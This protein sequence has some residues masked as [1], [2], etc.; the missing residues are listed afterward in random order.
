MAQKS[1]RTLRVSLATGL[2]LSG[3]AASSLQAQPTP[4]ET[5]T[6]PATKASVSTYVRQGDNAF[7]EGDYKTALAAY[8]EALQLFQGSDYIYYN[9]G[10]AHR[11]LEDYSAAVTD[12][13]QAL[14]LNPRHSFAYLYRGM[15]HHALEAFD[16]AITDYTTLIELDPQNPVAHIS[17]AET[18]LSLDQTAAAIADLEAA[19]ALYKKQK[20]DRLAEKTMSR[21]RSLR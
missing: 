2:L 15:S 6:P 17:R 16:A 10:N 21:V 1:F 14:Q 19:A 13:T 20:N 7:A 12:Y 3:L 8:S 9:R 5:D 11:K 4:A 18:Y